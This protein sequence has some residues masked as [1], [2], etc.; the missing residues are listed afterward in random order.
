VD[1]KGEIMAKNREVELSTII[2]KD[3]KVTGSLFVKGGVR[4]DGEVEGKIESDGF[5]TI[6]SS[7]L[8]KSD[9]K[10]KECLVSGKVKGNIIAEESLELDKSAKLDGDIITRILRIHTGAIF[11]GNCSM[12]EKS[13]EAKFIKSNALQKEQ[14]TDQ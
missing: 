2:G 6:G 5:V 12:Q 7:G 1:N 14:K 4:V 9:I 10:A 8:A 13:R 3:S 11:N